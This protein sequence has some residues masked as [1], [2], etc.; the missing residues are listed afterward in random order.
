MSST[1]CE[2]AQ[3]APDSVDLVG[4]WDGGEEEAVQTTRQR[5][6][7]TIEQ[8]NLC[9]STGSTRYYEFEVTWQFYKLSI[10]SFTNL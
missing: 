2:S 3:L 1:V 7:T 4:G 10:L 8:A 5:A 6:K 9:S